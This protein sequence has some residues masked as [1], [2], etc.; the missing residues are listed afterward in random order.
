MEV[1]SP[2]AARGSLN[3]SLASLGALTVERSGLQAKIDKA[4]AVANDKFGES[5]AE[6]DALIAQAQID[7]A[8]AIARCPEVLDAGAVRL[9]NLPP[10]VVVSDEAVLLAALEAV[11][12][13]DCIRRGTDSVDK[14]AL[15]KHAP[16]VVGYEIRQGVRLGVTPAATKKE[17]SVPI[18]IATVA[19]TA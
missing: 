6:I 14:T 3:T 16:P 17:I 18:T 7:I 12:A 11:G 13:T 8:D 10:S 9:V 2:D 5:I 19:Q 15:K 1:L 4:T